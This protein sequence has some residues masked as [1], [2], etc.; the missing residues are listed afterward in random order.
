MAEN[1]NNSSVGT[2][3][4]ILDNVIHRPAMNNTAI[5]DGIYD[6]III[7][8]I[9]KQTPSAKSPTGFRKYLQIKI[10]VNAEDDIAIVNYFVNVSWHE[11]SEMF[12]MLTELRCMPAENSDF[13]IDKL[14]DKKVTVV[15]KNVEKGDKTYPNVDKLYAQKVRHTSAKNTSK[16]IPDKELENLD[17]LYEDDE[18]EKIDENDDDE[19]II[20]FFVDDEAEDN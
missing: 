8:A 6:G 10:E 11:K 4:S 9:Q 16:V 1:A 18:D 13:N 5:D 12:Q 15:V 17:Y 14:K 3:S 20:D 19:E 7:D 2:T